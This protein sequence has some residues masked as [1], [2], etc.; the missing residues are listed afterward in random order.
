M[1]SPE[2][3]K[4]SSDRLLNKKTRLLSFD[5]KANLVSALPLNIPKPLTPIYQ[6]AL[7]IGISHHFILKMRKNINEHYRCKK[8]I[9][10]NG[11]Y[12]VIEC[13]KDNLKTLQDI[14]AW[15]I[16]AKAKIHSAVHSY[17]KGKSIITNAR[18]T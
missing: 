2:I 11:K 7:D 3:I 4:V 8:T 16:S 15:K 17:Q 1:R 9:K 5:T 18:P 14:I 10:R 12:R 13:P 6:F